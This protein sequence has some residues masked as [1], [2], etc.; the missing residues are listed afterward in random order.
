MASPN[1]TYCASCGSG[2]TCTCGLDPRNGLPWPPSCRD[3][4]KA[5]E[6]RFSWVQ[7]AFVRDNIKRLG[8]RLL[9]ITV[10]MER[11]PFTGSPAALIYEFVGHVRSHW[12]G[13]P[14]MRVFVTTIDLQTTEVVYV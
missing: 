8:D 2:K 9:L 12:R 10:L 4:E 5:I 13:L 11:A 3:L 14:E 1:V 6:S 7:N